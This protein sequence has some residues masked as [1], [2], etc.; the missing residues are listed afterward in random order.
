MSNVLRAC[1]G[2]LDRYMQ[3][4]NSCPVL[5]REEEEN[6][7]RAW[8]EKR[9]KNA[10]QRLVT[11]HVRLAIKIAMGYRNYGLVMVDMISEG[12][13]GLVKAVQK[14]T[15]SRGVRF[16][17][18]ASWWVR[19]CIQNFIVK[20]WSLVRVGTTTAQRK[21]FFGLRK[22]RNKILQ[23][24]GNDNLC[25]E[26]ISAIA[27]HFAVSNSEV[28]DM[29]IRMCGQDL[30][31]NTTVPG[32]QQEF[33]DIFRCS[34]VSAEDN[35]IES[36]SSS[37]KTTAL[38]MAMNSLSKRE[39]EVVTMRKLLEKP[40]SL[41]KLAEKYAISAERV[42]QIQEAAMKKLSSFVRSIA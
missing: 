19:A 40:I 4:A 22:M 33:L 12:V 27:K 28:K 38:L 6:L 37:H 24:H 25:D 23:Y 9:D 17:T 35:L 36:E 5:E 11:S 20:S 42:R 8:V 2:L 32:G 3:L 15:P 16:A 10:A 39:R 13:V 41:E 30:S 14:F 31:L 29:E 21:L 34:N 1:D 26:G 18:Y 7:A